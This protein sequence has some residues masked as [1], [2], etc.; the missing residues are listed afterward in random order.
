[1]AKMICYKCGKPISEDRSSGLC[2]ACSGTAGRDDKVCAS[3]GAQKF[4]GS[5][6]CVKCG[7]R[8]E[9][10]KKTPISRPTRFARVEVPKIS[11]KSRFRALVLAVLFGWTIGAHRFYAGRKTSGVLMLALSVIGWVTVLLGA[12]WILLAP[13][14]IWVIIDFLFII[15]GAFKD[16]EGK[17]IKD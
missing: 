15:S 10:E 3:C 17:A 14:F 4:P 7:A 6:I 12:G 11:D 1:M 2:A 5:E 9:R 8:F 13:V 16:G